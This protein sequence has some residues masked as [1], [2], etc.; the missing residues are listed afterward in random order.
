MRFSRKYVFYD[1]VTIVIKS[2]SEFIVRIFKTIQ[3][4]RENLTWDDFSEVARNYFEQRVFP[5][6]PHN[7]IYLYIT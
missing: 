1:V 3:H 7:N 2:P 6:H 4:S 5:R